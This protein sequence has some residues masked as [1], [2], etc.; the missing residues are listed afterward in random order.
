MKSNENI[1][2]IN[3]IDINPNEVLPP[4]KKTITSDKRNKIISDIK[5]IFFDKSKVNKYNPTKKGNKIC[6]LR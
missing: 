3:E 5:N 6:A 1:N 4:D 2:K